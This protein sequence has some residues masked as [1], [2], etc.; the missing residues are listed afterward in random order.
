MTAQLPVPALLS[1][2]RFPWQALA[3]R[4]AAGQYTP[5]FVEQIEKLAIA[6]RYALGQLQRNPDWLDHLAELDRFSLEA[7]ITDLDTMDKI[8][9]DQVKSALRQYRH[10]KLVEI[11]FLDVI[12]GQP[13]QDSLR[14]LSDLADR[15][16]AKYSDGYVNP[17]PRR[18]E[19]NKAPVGVGYP[20]EWLGLT[21]YPHGPITVTSMLEPIMMVGIGG[22]VGFILIAMYLPIFSI[23][24]AIKPQ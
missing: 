8:D 4:L 15:L 24:D 11:I 22:I 7:S 12:A 18:P 3:E 17:K 19:E 21:N 14:Q 10:Q 13:L 5:A 20:S 2:D 16:I 9:L 23:A 6:S 1:E